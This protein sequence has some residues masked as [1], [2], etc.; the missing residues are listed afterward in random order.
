M[1]RTHGSRQRAILAW[2]ARNGDMSLDFLVGCMFQTEHPSIAQRD[3]TQHAVA[4]LVR[5]GTV[6][7]GAIDPYGRETWRLSGNVRKRPARPRRPRLIE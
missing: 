3:T 4:R 6:S 2:L 5:D 1:S 7:P